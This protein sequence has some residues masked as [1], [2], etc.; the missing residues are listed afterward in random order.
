[1]SYLDELE[2]RVAHFKSR[3]GNMCGACGKPITVGH[4]VAWMRKT[5][6]TLFHYPRCPHDAS[7]RLQRWRVALTAATLGPATTL[8]LQFHPIHNALHAVLRY[9]S[10]PCP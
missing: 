8:L 1:M 6:Q 2:P 10:I 5:P 3:Y 7:S 9:F 4:Q